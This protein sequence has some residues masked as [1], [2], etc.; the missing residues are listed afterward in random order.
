ME[1]LYLK[2]EIELKQ[3]VRLRVGE[4]TYG[5]EMCVQCLSHQETPTRL[6]SNLL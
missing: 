4:R 3:F 5:A 2:R 1:K 6:R